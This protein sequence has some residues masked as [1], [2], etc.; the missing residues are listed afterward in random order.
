MDT[1]IF[2]L[3]MFL[4]LTYLLFRRTASTRSRRYPTELHVQLGPAVSLKAEAPLEK[5]APAQ[6]RRDVNNSFPR[7]LA[8]GLTL[9]LPAGEALIA[10]TPAGAKTQLAAAND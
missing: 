1:L 10:Q 8:L 2:A 6:R 9:T 3:L 7:S 4:L 5:N